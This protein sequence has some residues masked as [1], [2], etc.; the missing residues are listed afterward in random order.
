MICWL[1]FLVVKNIKEQTKNTMA[2]RCKTPGILTTERSNF[3]NKE[4]KS[5][6][7][8]SL[9]ERVNIFIIVSLSATLP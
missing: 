6:K 2:I 8:K 1:R 9:R 4:R 7:P 5:P 3:G